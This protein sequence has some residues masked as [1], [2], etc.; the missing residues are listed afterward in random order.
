MADTI[1]LLDQILTAASARGMNQGELAEKAAFT[2]ES[3]SRAKAK[4]DMYVSSLERL[5]RAAGLRLMLVP[6]D[7][8]V[9]KIT[10]GTLFE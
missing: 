1:A 7:D 2:T 4:N 3:I 6:D 9:E 5:A 8:V 10:S